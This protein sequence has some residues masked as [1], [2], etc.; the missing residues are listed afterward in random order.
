M[1]LF[2]VVSAALAILAA[3]VLGAPAPVQLKSIER[4]SG[5][6][7]PSSYIVKL[8]SGVSKEAQLEWLEKQ[9]SSRI[10]HNEWKAGVINGFA[11]TFDTDALNALRANP[12]VEAISED[13]RVS[14]AADVTQTN[15]P[16]GLA[17]LSQ[18]ARLSNQNTSALTFSY[19]YDDSAGEGVD[20]YIV[21]TGINTAH[22]D[23][24]GRARWGAT[25]G[26]YPSADG[27]GHGTHCAGTAAGTQYGVAKKANLIAVKV[28]DDSGG[29]F[30]SDIIS[31][32]DWVS[33][34]VAASGR[35][36]VASFSLSGGASSAFDAAITAIVN[37][38]I[39]VTVAA[40]NFNT[41][42][43]NYS[44][45]RAPAVITVGAST[46]ADARASFSN[47]GAVVDIFAPGQNVISA[48]RGSTTATNNISGTSM[49]TPHVAGLIASLITRDGNDTPAAYSDKL[50]ALAVNGI[51]TGIPSGTIN[52]LAQN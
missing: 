5:A 19:T 38:G 16:W 44:P 23:F 26:G 34:Q 12:D 36:S 30:Y 25:F 1:Q 37:Q 48:W 15:A 6:V 42:A 11:G 47:Y 50:K 4:V 32:L 35:P 7:K 45:A 46:I 51:L 3:P 20:I 40:G 27:H 8:K 41:N 14:I 43:A 21:D 28:L 29:G 22:V 13:G 52:A 49:A 9:G 24:G 10:T 2:A 31:A 18:P 33:D 17:R 39:H